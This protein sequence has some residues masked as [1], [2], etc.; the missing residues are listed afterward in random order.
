MNKLLTRR[1]AIVTCVSDP[2]ATLIYSTARDRERLSA[3]EHVLREVFA[4]AARALTT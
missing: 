1:R 4:P 3:A 2:P